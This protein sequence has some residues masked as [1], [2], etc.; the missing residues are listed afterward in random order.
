M[1][2]SILIIDDEKNVRISLGNLLKDYGYKV[3]LA[4]KIIEAERIL[5]AEKIDLVIL[6][7]VLNK[8]DGLDWLK[9]MNNRKRYYPTIVISG[10]AN[11]EILERAKEIGT[12]GVIEKPFSSQGVLNMVKS[13]LKRK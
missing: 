10:N 1:E 4:E 6:D 2:S 9:R 8:E 5:F 11:M 7:V 12:I 13:A 3:F